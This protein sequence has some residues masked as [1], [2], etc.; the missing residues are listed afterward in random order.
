MILPTLPVLPAAKSP[1]YSAP[2]MPVARPMK[3]MLP[4][5]MPTISPAVIPPSAPSAVVVLVVIVLVFVVVIVAVVVTVIVG[6]FVVVA[7]KQ[8]LSPTVQLQTVMFGVT[9]KP[10]SCEKGLKLEDIDVDSGIRTE[11]KLCLE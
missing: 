5:A 8:E 7:P 11:R 10:H 6:V 4:N 9:S 1:L 2:A 3:K